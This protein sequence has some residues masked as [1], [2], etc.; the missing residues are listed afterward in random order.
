M[1]RRAAE[2]L[3][4]PPNTGTLKAGFGGFD[5]FDGSFCREEFFW[6]LN[7]LREA[8]PEVSVVSVVRFAG[9]NFFLAPQREVGRGFRRFRQCI[10]EGENIFLP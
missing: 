5:G 7:W 9:K 1:A 10:S 6:A 4:L 8:G 3:F 2:S